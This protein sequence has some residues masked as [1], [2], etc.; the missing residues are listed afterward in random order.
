ML[1]ATHVLAGS[2]IYKA[3]ENRILAYGLAFG[4]HYLL[5]LIPHYELNSKPNYILFAATGL[6]LGLT[7]WKQKDWGILIA[8]LLS[9]FPDINWRSGRP[10]PETP[11]AATGR[12]NGSSQ[13]TAN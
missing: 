8:G 11:N 4:S 10:V 13:R 9:V 3:V 7:A 12:A 2:A 1:G 5:D 6:G